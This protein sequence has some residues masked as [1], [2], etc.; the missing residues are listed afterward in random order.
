MKWRLQQAKRQLAK[1]VQ[2]ANE[3]EP[4]MITLRGKDAAVILSAEEYR[5]LIRQQEPDFPSQTGSIRDLEALLSSTEKTAS[6]EDLDAAIRKRAALH[7][8]DNPSSDD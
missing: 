3:Q 5:R 4:Q 1:V 6:L 2:A 7:S 8:V